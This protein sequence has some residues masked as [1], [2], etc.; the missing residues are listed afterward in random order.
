MDSQK[1]WRALHSCRMVGHCWKSDALSR[2][3]S[4]EETGAVRTIRVQMLSDRRKVVAVFTIV[5]TYHPF[6]EP[7]Y[8]SGHT[9]PFPNS[10]KGR[11][12]HEMGGKLP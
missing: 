11:V 8:L 6:H 1:K 3:G 2:T 9:S 4:K 12:L 7:F 10:Q 5:A